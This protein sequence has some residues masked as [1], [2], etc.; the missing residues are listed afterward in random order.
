MMKRTYLLAMILFALFIQVGIAQ[1]IVRV[2]DKNSDTKRGYLVGPRDKIEGKILGEEQFGFVVTVDEDGTFEVP[3]V[4]QRI[5]A[6]CRTESEIRE[7]VKTHLGKYLR[8][9][10]VSVQVTERRKPIP[11]TVSGE[12]QTP[13][14]VTLTRKTRLLE[15]LTFSGGAKESA[16]GTVRVFRPQ[17]SMCAGK[18]EIADWNEES[19]NGKFTPSRMYSLS[20]IEAGRKQSNPII[21][22]GDIISIE[23]A[24]PVYINGEV[25]NRTGVYIREGGLSLTEALAKVGGV[26]QKAK[27][28]DIKIYRRIPD[29]TERSVIAVNLKLIK[30]KQQKDIMLEPYDIIDVGTKKKSIGQIIF[31][32]VAGAGKSAATS[33]ATGGARI[34]Y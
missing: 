23:K 20:G 25:S 29:S 22:D 4:D 8:N 1:E 6:K 13:G 11:V 33:F 34:L 31:E 9:P 24:S 30:T 5:V 3:F 12:V 21:N 26:R 27:I 16:G 19:D 15:I 14:Q 32:I 17:V 28:K 7:D 18:K 10:L 2:S